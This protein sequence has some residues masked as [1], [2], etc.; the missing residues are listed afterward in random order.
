MPG[1][2]RELAGRI[3]GEDEQGAS[4]APPPSGQERREGCC[5]SGSESAVGEV[6]SR[7]ALGDHEARPGGAEGEADVAAA[8]RDLGAAF[9]PRV[10]FCE[11]VYLTA[12]DFE[13]PGP[14]PGEAVALRD[15]PLRQ[16]ATRIES[17]RARWRS[18][19]V[20]G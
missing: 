19:T 10:P 20:A 9:P 11:P 8:P 14:G 15:Q 2:I 5:G 4:R 17:L 3:A 13:P 12:D 16:I 18:A 7:G 6:V 1:K